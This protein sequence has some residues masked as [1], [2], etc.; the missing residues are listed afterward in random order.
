M[1]I[2]ARKTYD[3]INHDKTEITTVNTR[4]IMLENENEG[5][6]KINDPSC[7]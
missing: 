2:S 4:E 3:M 7:A 5:E 1:I 6:H